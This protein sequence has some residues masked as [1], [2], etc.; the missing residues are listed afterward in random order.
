MRTLVALV[1]GVLLYAC[2]GASPQ[3]RAEEPEGFLAGERVFAAMRAEPVILMPQH[4]TTEGLLVEL[5]STLARYGSRADV[6]LQ[7]YRRADR[8][9]WRL[10]AVVRAV[11]AY[12]FA[13]EVVGETRIMLPLDVRAEMEARPED[14]EAV[15]AAFRA[16]VQSVLQQ[17]AQ[18][19]RCR[20]QRVLEELAPSRVA[21]ADAADLRTLDELR[22][23]LTGACGAAP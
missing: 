17:T 7:G 14:A 2:G 18:R 12:R 22:A 21:G 16:Q 1:A 9:P 20:A 10:R 19:L 8:Q 4:E 5:Q 11:E 3:S 13:A 6:A 15:E 23:E